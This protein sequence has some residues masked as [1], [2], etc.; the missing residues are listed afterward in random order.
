MKSSSFILFEFGAAATENFLGK[1]FHARRFVAAQNDDL[2]NK[3]QHLKFVE[4]ETGRPF[5]AH[6]WS[7]RS[8]KN[9]RFYFVAHVF[10]CWVGDHVEF[11]PRE[12]ARDVVV[13]RVCLDL[14]ET[15]I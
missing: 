6:E 13:V 7:P 8:P 2:R 11:V 14:I 3:F 10:E 15:R 12:S 5:V 1:S 4:I 9:Q